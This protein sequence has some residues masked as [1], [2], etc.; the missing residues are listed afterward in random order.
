M[1]QLKGKAAI[2]T[3]AGG[4]LGRAICQT[5]AA[6]GALVIAADL[7]LARAEDVASQLTKEGMRAQAIAS[8]VRKEDDIRQLITRALSAFGHLDILINNACMSD[9][10]IAAGDIN[11]LTL[12]PG[13][14]DEIMA[15]NARGPMLACK[16][17]IPAMTDGG[18]IV[19]IVSV[20]A[21]LGYDFFF[22]Y[23]ASKAAL[24]ALTRYVATAFG[25]R[26][27]RCNAVAP[28]TI[29]HERLRA[30]MPQDALDDV[31]KHQLLPMSGEARDIAEA[32]AYLAGP[33]AKFVTGQILTVDGGYTIHHPNY[34][35]DAK[36]WTL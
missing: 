26:G 14:W 5:L 18:S 25:R 19:N 31:L 2:V 30:V 3:G 28:G 35:A 24:I 34:S 6:Q 20:Q 7:N 32:V 27:I 8:D 13:V 12:E 23:G 29:P 21:L 17:A 15:V 11:L 33:A 16:H 9:P 10:A 1:N 4:G 36:P 22:A